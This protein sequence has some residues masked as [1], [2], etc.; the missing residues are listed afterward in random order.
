MAIGFGVW[1]GKDR[2][3]DLSSWFGRQAGSEAAASVLGWLPLGGLLLYGAVLLLRATLAEVGRVE[4]FVSDA[5]V[6]VWLALATIYF[7][8][9]FGSD[10]GTFRDELERGGESFADAAVAAETGLVFTIA[11]I[12]VLAVAQ[13][14]SPHWQSG[15]PD[16]ERR[17]HL[18]SAAALGLPALI[19][20]VASV[21]V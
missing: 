1:V 2:L 16:N 8:S 20:L 7:W 3:G 4:R 10:W 9:P 18:A 12:V 19:A 14:V 13:I 11:G 15:S 17:S 5:T 6:I 21:A